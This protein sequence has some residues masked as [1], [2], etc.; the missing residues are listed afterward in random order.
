ML[1]LESWAVLAL[2]FSL[3]V[4]IWVKK[5]RYALLTVGLL[6]HLCLEYSLNIPMFQWD[7]LSAYVLFID[8]EHLMRAWDWITG[9][10]GR[11]GF[12]AGV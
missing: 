3:G 4:L 5:L 8:P 6:L 11:Q 7:I 12:R 1:K 10:V 2:E 9:G